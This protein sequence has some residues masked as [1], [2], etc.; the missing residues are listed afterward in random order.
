MKQLFLHHRI[1][2]ANIPIPINLE[3]KSSSTQDSRLRNTQYGQQ[4][5][6]KVVKVRGY[7][8]KEKVEIP[9]T[10]FVLSVHGAKGLERFKNMQVGENVSLALSID[11]KWMDSEFM[12]ASG[13]MLLK[14]GKPNITMDTSNW[15][16]STLYSAYGYR[17]Q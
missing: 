13:P 8:S 4:V 14:D 17:H 10:G 12:L 1:L 7:G 15:R 6:G 5:T 11:D 9:K 16:S 2:T 3:L